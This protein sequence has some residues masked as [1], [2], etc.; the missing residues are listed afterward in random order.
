MSIQLHVPPALPQRNKFGNHQTGRWMATTFS[1]EIFWKKN[2]GSWD[3]KIMGGSY[4]LKV[5]TAVSSSSQI[6]NTKFC[7]LLTCIHS[8]S[9]VPHPCLFVVLLST[10]QFASLHPLV[11]PGPS[12]FRATI[13]F[14]LNTFTSIG[15]AH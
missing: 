15:S 4:V 3:S 14:S 5:L 13:V 11:F 8:F 12:A 6:S 2:F 7:L 1:L 10:V 9:P